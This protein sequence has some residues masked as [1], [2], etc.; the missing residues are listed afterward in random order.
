MDRRNLKFD[1]VLLITLCTGVIF[2]YSTYAWFSSSLNVEI[3]SFN[4]TTESHDELLL[5]LDGKTW[6]DRVSISK[7]ILY[8]VLP[9]TYPTQKS[10]WSD[11]LF[12]VST[13]GIKDNTSEL[14][15]LFKIANPYYREIS[16]VNKDYY[17]VTLIDELLSK[18][19]SDFISFDLF[20]KNTTPSP[21]DD[22]LYLNSNTGIISIGEDNIASNSS[23]IGLLFY[24]QIPNTSS[25][26]E[27]QSI[28]CNEKCYS[29][30]YEPNASKHTEDAI[31]D[32]SKH[33][34]SIID[35]YSYPTYGV[36]A[37][38]K[39]VPVWAGVYKSNW[40]INFN[41]F[42][43]QDTFTSINT[44]IGELGEEITKVRVYVWIEGQD[45]DCLERESE[46]YTL[47]VSLGFRKEYS[48]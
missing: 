37:E 33:G 48:K 35:G 29:M 1:L 32:S 38:G 43:F 14:F 8:N 13:L 31:L 2:I 44:K 36:R 3:T 26:E 9:E 25:L 34:V 47:S 6:S 40:D 12:T 27:I 16:Y 19:D 46:G 15:T 23:R 5:S 7:D 41:Y 10:I 17:V 42:D 18:D 11:K 24:D 21:Y 4:I 22:Y 45:I 30:I 28:T 20:L 39:A